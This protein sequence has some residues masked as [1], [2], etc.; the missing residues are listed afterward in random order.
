[1][2][3][4]V[5][6]CG[7]RTASALTAAV[8]GGADYLG[9]VFYGPSPRNLSFCEAGELRLLVP[10]T[11]ASVALVV[12]ADD[13]E[14]ERIIRVL[15]PGI[16][17]AHGAETP[18]RIAAIK[19]RFG[20]HVWKALPVASAGDIAAHRAYVGAADLVLFDAKPP[21]GMKNALPGGNALSFDWS[22]LADASIDMPWG[23]AGGLNPDNVAEAVRI[24]GAG[25]IDTSSGVE[26]APGV[27][28]EALIAAFLEAAGS[29]G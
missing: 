13:A 28:D 12:N 21:A 14:I 7:L 19:Q 22:L 20:V 27:K 9:F 15:G 3:P 25:L 17:Q 11:V 2:S 23:L 6:I 8:R 16:V 4:K 5:K 10:P 24:T 26:S 1:M 29:D 18:E